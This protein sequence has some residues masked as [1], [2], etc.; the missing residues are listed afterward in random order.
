MQLSDYTAKDSIPDQVKVAILDTDGDDDPNPATLDPAKSMSD[1]GFSDMLYI[2]LT[3][4][5]N[6][7]AKKYNADANISV[8]S[9][10][11]SSTVQD[12]IDLVTTAAG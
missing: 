9:V 10:Q 4:D 8:D 12:C 5:F 6:T 7:I 2:D 11:N 3:G 1:F